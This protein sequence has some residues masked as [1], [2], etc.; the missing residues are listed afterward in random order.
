MIQI[1][2]IAASSEPL[3]QPMGAKA[4]N[5]TQNQHKKKLIEFFHIHYRK[6]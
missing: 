5:W 1:Q 6:S 3:D 4:L 2:G